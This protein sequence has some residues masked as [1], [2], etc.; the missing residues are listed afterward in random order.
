M[1][2]PELTS[3]KDVPTMDFANLLRDELEKYT[4]IHY[5][6]TIESII[7]Q[8]F[9]INENSIIILFNGN[10]FLDKNSEVLSFLTKA[11]KMKCVFYP[12]AMNQENR[13]PISP[14]DQKQSFDLYDQIRHR[15][16]PEAFLN[17]K[18]QLEDRC[19][20]EDYLNVI[21]GTLGRVIYSHT[22][23]T[24]FS[25]KKFIFISHKRLDGEDATA[26]LTEA[27]Q[28][29]FCQ[30]KFFRDLP[31]V[32]VGDEAQN[33]IDKA[34]HK[35]DAFIF[36]HTPK[37]GE[38][39]WIK[40]ELAFA[41]TRSIPIIWIKV[42]DAKNLD[43]PIPFSKPHFELSMKDFDDTE[44]VR[45]LCEQ[46]DVLTFDQIKI[47]N[48]E[49]WKTAN[50]F[51]QTKPERIK[52]MDKDKLIYSLSLPRS[53]EYYK[54]P[55]RDIKFIIQFFGRPTQ[56]EDYEELEKFSKLCE[57]CNETVDSVILLSNKILHRYEA[58]DI[59][60]EYYEDFF[61]V[62]EH[63]EGN[64]SENT[65][66][67]IVISGAF[68]ES[69]SAY[70]QI[71]TDALVVFVKTF[72]RAGYK[73]TFGSHPSF[74]EIMFKLAKDIFPDQSKERLEMFISDYF[75]KKFGI[76]TTK[77]DGSANLTITPTITGKDENDSRLQS[78]TLMRQRM[79]SR[80]S[81]KA[82]VC[83]GGLIKKD[84]SKEEGVREEVAIAQKS[85]VPAFV[86]GSVG[87][88]SSMI[89]LEHKNDSRW[90]KL[91]NASEELNKRFMIDLNYRALAKEMI[92][93][94]K[95]NGI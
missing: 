75:V 95:E 88:C 57:T 64:T 49:L 22:Q 19:L 91:N 28:G 2:S 30:D 13:I 9:K 94:L 39:V 93:Y 14:A 90:E 89:A 31:E 76:D 73:V 81:V 21:A 6:K 24:M 11:D 87:G 50:N 54:Y 56:N 84:N 18:K 3:N 80:P 7:N 33:V 83:L 47:F 8:N 20:P 77:F 15:S 5:I 26:T 10:D 32:M 40:K 46:I 60:C 12:V 48:S 25:K 55:Q 72:L 58:N 42:N 69:L 29:M 70:E 74:Q 66:H 37:S 4:T 61:H 38:S 65:D 44:K 82:L 23:P 52:I 53:I 36:L 71:L 34:M 43:L 63:Y 68:P 27:L 62:L 16:L 35:S 85:D 45:S 17:V 67:E 51:P 78:L 41:V 1:L 92:E 59:I 79:I 86:I